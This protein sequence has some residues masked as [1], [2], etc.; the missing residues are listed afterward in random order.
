ME[1]FLLR[2]AHDAAWVGA[3]ILLFAVIGVIATIR[4]IMGMIFRGERAVEGGVQSAERM[5][6]R[7]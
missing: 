6:H 1:Q 2:I 7:Q 4:W 5:I 3:F